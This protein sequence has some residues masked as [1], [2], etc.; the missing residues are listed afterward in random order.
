MYNYF[1]KMHKGTQERNKKT[2][3]V[4]GKTKN[5]A[6]PNPNI[7]IKILNTNKPNVPGDTK[8]CSNISYWNFLEIELKHEGEIEKK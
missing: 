2:G 3:S 8:H 4:S 6:Q 7:F 5:V 1:L